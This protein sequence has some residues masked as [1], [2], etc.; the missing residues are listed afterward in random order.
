VTD[1]ARVSAVV[2][3]FNCERYLAE[4]IE[5]ALDQTLPPFEVVVV[6]DGST[7]GTQAVARGY[8]IR[9]EAQAHAGIGTARNRGVEAAGG[10]WVAFLDGDD[11][12][13]A[14]RLD[15]LVAAVASDAELDIVFGHVE[16]FQSG[17]VPAGAPAPRRLPG[18]LPSAAL[19][20][21]RVFE[22]VG[23]FRTDLRTGEFVDWYLRALEVGCRSVL[24]PE[25]TLERR[26]HA[27]NLSRRREVWADYAR[28]VKASLD[29]R[30][31]SRDP[32][33]TNR[34]AC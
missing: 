22:N 18:Y 17:P 5:S 24:L 10:E 34:A 6:D 33:D 20:R 16:E 30:R 1:A 23:P 27:A 15:C 28:I 3:A 32:S 31:A 21:R 7:D 14:E 13:P 9:L 8:P 12:W 19:I 11:R 26:L 2:T 25:V 4:A 29:R